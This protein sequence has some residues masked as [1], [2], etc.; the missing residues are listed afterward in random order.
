VTDELTWITR[1][2]EH[3]RRLR[4]I[5]ENARPRVSALIAEVMTIEQKVQLTTERIRRWREQANLKAVHDAG[6]A[7]EA[8]VRLKLASARA[9]VSQ[10][11]TEIRGARRGSPFARSI[12]EI[13]DA[14]ATQAGVTYEP[15]NDRSL[16]AEAAARSGAVPKWIGFLLSFD[17]D[18]RKRRL[19]FLIEGQNRLYQMVG[20]PG[21]EDLDPAAVDRLKRK[22]YDCVNKLAQR[23]TIVSRSPVTCNLIEDIFRVAPSAAE[24]RD[25]SSFAQAFTKQH[26]EKLDRLIDCLSADIDLDAS[27]RDIDVLLAGAE[28]WPARSLH[29][30]LVNYLGFPFWDVLTFPIL[31]WREAGEFNEIR[32]DRISAQDTRGLEQLGTFPLKGVAFNQFAAFLSR[33]YREND[34]LL[35]RLHAIDRLIDFVHDAGG[36][37]FLTPSFVAGL[38]KKAFLTIL[39]TE[40]AHLPTC[41]KLIAELRTA[42][43][44]ESG[45]A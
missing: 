33:S 27:T 38:K 37:D 30:V 20:S 25:L 41:K 17:V 7:Y 19:R 34:Y 14:W 35:G 44:S 4:T 45:S 12:A 2:N 16:L 21:F 13:I 8:Y 40:D 31:P 42:L 3:V 11:I 36:A 23:E 43:M 39:D 29:E 1:F 24:C 5:I 32:V 10:T 18:Y 15:T 6:F 26:R 22:F 28:G 9:F